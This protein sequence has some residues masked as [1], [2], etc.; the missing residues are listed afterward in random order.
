MHVLLRLG[1][2]AAALAALAAQRLRKPQSVQYD[3]VVVGGGV[4]GVWA[5]IAAARQN[6][7]VCLV[8]KYAEGH[9]R[10]SSHGDGRIYRFAYADEIYVDM[11]YLSLSYWGELNNATSKVLAHTGGVSL[12]SG[13]GGNYDSHGG[14]DDLTKIYRK[15]GLAHE[16]LSRKKLKERFPQFSAPKNTTAL[17]QPDFGVLFADVA[18]CVEI[19]QR[20]GALL[21]PS[22]G[23]EPASPRHRRDA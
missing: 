1:A 2:A 15:R 6:R 8:E 7:T 12:Y 11:M 22:S 14:L 16:K 9:A 5:A 23:E 17:Y 18:I 20:A 21:A 10:G 4:M 13:Q 19:N 3:V